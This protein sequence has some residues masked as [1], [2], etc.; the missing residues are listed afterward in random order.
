M[1]ERTGG[2]FGLVVLTVT[3]TS[4]KADVSDYTDISNTRVQLFQG[5][6]SANITVPITQDSEP[7]L[8]E[9]FEVS[10]AISSS[11]SPATLGAITSVTVI[12]DSSDSP[13][14]ELGFEEPLTYNEP[15][16]TSV[17]TSLNLLVERLGGSIG[18]TQV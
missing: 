17:P 8:Q 7:E 14:G 2:D 3:L 4:G 12:I 5:E 15:N 18:Q 16:P 13:H 9:Q 10:V 6:S 1:V 11:S